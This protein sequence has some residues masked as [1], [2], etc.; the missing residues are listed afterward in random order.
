MV[1]VARGALVD[2]C[3]R[4]GTVLRRASPSQHAALQARLEDI[5]VSIPWP[6]NTRKLHGVSWWWQML[7]ASFDRLKGEECEIVQ[8]L[9][10]VGFDGRGFDFVRGERRRRSINSVEISE[11]IEYVTAFGAERGVKFREFERAA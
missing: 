9:D 3:H 8:A 2:K 5:A 4:C 1:A 10:G 7:V 6:P 11:I